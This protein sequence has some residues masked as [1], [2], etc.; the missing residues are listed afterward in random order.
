M[1]ADLKETSSKRSQSDSTLPRLQPVAERVRSIWRFYPL[2]LVPATSASSLPLHSE[3]L[4]QSFWLSVRNLYSWTLTRQLGEWIR[5]G[6]WVSSP[7]GP[8]QS[9][10]SISTERMRVISAS[11][12]SL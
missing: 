3:Q 12:A 2:A 4:L 10:Q 8:G 6:S 9:Y 5:T 11:L 7:K 1:P